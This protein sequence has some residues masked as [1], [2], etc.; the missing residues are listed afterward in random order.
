MKTVILTNKNS[1]YG[2]NLIQQIENSGLTIEAIVII[3]QPLS[4]HINLFNYV[5]KRVGFLQAIYFSTEAVVKGIFKKNKKVNYSDFKAKSLY[6]NANNSY[7]LEQILKDLQTDII[8]LGQTGIIRKNIID[9]ANKGVLNAHPGI[10]P[11]YRGIDCL[12]WAVLN[13]DLSKIG[14]SVHWVDTGVD[15]GN[16]ISTRQYKIKSNYSF[17]ALDCDI[18][19]QG[20]NELIAVLH[21][22]DT[23]VP[24]QS[25][26][27]TKEIGK[28]FY[29]MPLPEVLRVNKIL[30]KLKNETF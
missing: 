26:P 1:I 28:Q 8:V 30:K 13:N 5:K 11:E 25:T 6:V 27:Q 23:G 4:Y 14:C 3:N 2:K 19:L 29:K 10:L 21:K 12:K 16:I 20:I 22:L 17:E 15:T 18:Y 24:I 7:E 9:S